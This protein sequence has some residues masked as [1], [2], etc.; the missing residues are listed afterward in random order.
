MEKVI[1]MR[2]LLLLRG[3]PGSGKSTFL[4]QQ[5]LA[6]YTL[7]ADTLRLLYS[8]PVLDNEGRWCI[9]QR[10]DKVMW[11]LLMNLLEERMRR[12]CFTVVDATNI[13]G[14]DMTNYKKL[15]NE[16]KYR[17]YVV[18]FTDVP[19]AEALQ[20]NRLREEYKQVPE[21][22]IKRMH[23]Q[24]AD[25]KVPSGITVIKP[26]ELAHIWYKPRDLSAYKK[27][28]HI[29]D[30]HGCC[31]PLKEY[32]QEI[33]PENYYVFLGDYIDRGRENAE[34]IKLL[35]QLAQLET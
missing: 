32:L 5:G 26:E 18:D 28:I 34:V 10:F 4:R 20:R 8:S 7:S 3:V 35:L 22:V 16:Y 30:I 23:A 24:L 6:P 1:T 14:K 29:G 21:A 27:V 9:S 2:I 11:P 31:K 13:R 25:N 17:V 12:G 19:L 33:S 15:A